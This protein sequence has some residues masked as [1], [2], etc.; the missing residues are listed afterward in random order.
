MKTRFYFFCSLLVI[1]FSCRPIAYGQITGVHRICS[2]D[3]DV[4]RNATTGGTWISSNTGVATIGSSSGLV[5]GVSAGTAIISYIYSGGSDGLLFTVEESPSISMGIMPTVC[6]GDTIANITYT[7]TTGSPQYSLRWSDTAIAAGFGNTPDIISTIAGDYTLRFSYTGDG[8]AATAAGLYTSTSIARDKSGNLYIGE[9]YY[10]ERVRKVSPAGIIT[11]VAGTGIM[12]YSGDGGPA[13][14]CEL[15]WI[16]S[17]T[18]D[19]NGNLYIADGGNYVVRKVNPAG[20]ITTIAGNGTLGFSGDGGPATSAQFTVINGMVTD[21]AGNLYLSDAQSGCIRRIDLRGIVTTVAGVGFIGSSGYSG[22]GGNATAAYFDYPCGLALDIA[23][24]LYIADKNNGVLRKVTPFGIISTVAGDNAVGFAYSGDGGPA[25]NAGLYQPNSVAVDKYGTLYIAQDFINPAIA[26]YIRKVTPNGI[27]STAVGI[28]TGSSGYSGDGGPATAA[29]INTPY[30][31]VVDEVGDIYFSDMTN[32]LIRK[33][34]NKSHLSSSP[35]PIAVPVGCLA[36]TYHGVLSAHSGNCSSEYPISV[37]VSAPP[38]TPGVIIGA[39]SVC[40]GRTTAFT[41]TTT[42][43]AW[44]SSNTAIAYVGTTGIVTGVSAGSAL[45]TY[46]VSNVCGS[47]FVTK[48]IIVNPSIPVSQVITTVAGN[49][50]L[51]FSGD[52]G[53]ATAGMLGTPF[54]VCTDAAGNMYIADGRNHVV[55]KIDLAG[56]ITTFAG[57]GAGGFSGDGGQATNAQLN[58]PFG[59]EVDAIGQVYIA[60]KDN[61]RIRKVDLS[62]VITTIAGTY[63]RGSAGDG[64]PAILAQLFHPSR[65]RIAATGEIYIADYSNHKIRMIDTAGLIATYAGSVQGYGGDGAAATSAQLNFPYDMALSGDGNLYIADC[66]NHRIRV[67]DRAGVITTIAGNGSAGYGG[68]A[69]PA[70]SAMLNFPTCV[71]TDASGIVYIADYGNSRIRTIN[72]AGNITTFAGTGTSGYSGDGGLATNAKLNRPISIMVDNT[73]RLFIADNDNYRIRRVQAGIPNITGTNG[74]C[75]GNSVVMANDVTGGTWSTSDSFVASIDSLGTL[76]GNSVGTATISYTITNTCGSAYTIKTITVNPLPNAGV[77]VGA[78]T[79]AIGATITLANTAPGG[80]WSSSNTAKATVGSGTGVVTG[81]AAGSATISY[82]V[83][84][85]CGSAL[86]TK[87][88]AITVFGSISPIN[89]IT[90]VCTGSTSTLTDSTA[91][92]TWSSSNNTIAT[93]GSVSGV[94]SGV[95]SGTA[96]VT[97]R[98]STAYATAV[99]TVGP[100]STPI[101]GANTVCVGA[102]TPFSNTTTG[103]RWSSSVIA[104][105]AVGSATGIVTGV[106][107]GSATITYTLGSGCR[108]TKAVNVSV[109]PAAIGGLSSVCRAA[110]ITLTNATAGGKWM[111]SNTGIALVGSTT[112]V[113]T[114]VAAGIAVITY[115]TAAGCMATKTLSVNSVSSIQ[116]ANR[117]CLGNS[118][119]LTDST[120]GGIWSSGSTLIARVGTASGIVTGVGAGVTAISYSAGSCRV[121]FT[122]TVS[123]F[124]SIGG[125]SSVCQGQTITLTNTLTGG[126]WSSG[127]ISL[128]TVGSST[129]IV[130]GIAAGPVNI[131]YILP[132]GCVSVKPLTVSAIAAITGPTSICRGQSVTLTNAIS[133]GKWN[134]TSG[135]IAT[136]GSTTGIVNGIA[137]GFTTISYTVNGCR[138]TMPLTV[139]ALSAITGTTNIVEGQVVTLTTV[140]AGRWSSDNIGVASIGSGT[141]QVTGVAA[142]TTQITFTTTTGCAAMVTMTVNRVPAITGDT[143][144]CVGQRT[145]LSNPVAGGTWISGNSTIA[146]I[147]SSTGIVYGVTGGAVYIT[148]RFPTGGYTVYHFLVYRLPLL[149]GPSSVCAG[150]QI[151][152]D[153]GECCGYFTSS[154]S[155]VATVDFRSGTVTGVA[156]G[157]SLISYTLPTG[158]ITST[159]VIVKPLLPITGATNVCVGDTIMLTDALSGG[160]WSSSRALLASVGSSTGI[161]TGISAGVVT[162]SYT[163]PT[164]GCTATMGISVNSCRKSQN[165]NQNELFSDITVYPNPNTGN[166]IIEGKLVTATNETVVVEVV[167]MLGQVV[168]RLNEVAVDGRLKIEIQ[169]DTRIARGI[170]V[171]NMMTASQQKVFHF[172]VSK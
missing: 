77:I 143:T 28:N 166:F 2:G 27:I 47:A 76:S 116:G 64:G 104:K 114:G 170:Y 127:N 80:V 46:L 99:V 36:G 73:G 18:V 111:S 69:G 25:T 9:G 130:S 169:L 44:S 167:D 105:A 67:V 16:S 31:V 84:N 63:R 3:F 41:N 147:G 87:S 48:S 146:T 17:L 53:P 151:T 135:L 12:G 121:T 113:V 79:V 78:G 59:V 39:S 66:Y 125:A 138:A 110:T 92:G 40:I 95:A 118:A 62:G 35:I 60:D 108:V 26:N 160:Y 144:V 98:V 145:S 100:L 51:G 11:T 38:S 134:S 97:Y 65:V 106:A 107:A 1:S 124:T 172:V 72:A 94:V 119:T 141:G 91:G 103:G 131:S 71:K 139:N 52:G 83:T 22:D 162:L 30:G 49:G 19:V 21:N 128:A 50:I 58:N 68:D 129:G 165:T 24:N 159:S 7:G 81:V 133:G 157:T 154:A 163:I 123:N 93:I 6:L 137:S 82:A 132:T 4:L 10:G 74:L 109:T 33:V 34:T 29:Q 112:G 171:L 55:R 164:T 161:V 14:N 20:I 155:G 42:G 54:D 120:T 85:S 23:G 142:G 8:G 5:T 88:I 156:A 168:F 115:S 57:N 148:Y 153:N 149:S 89:G 32:G 37:T 122:V 75:M 96:T 13:T 101:T 43:G 56:T 152:L 15:S 70:S 150:Q 86:A 158:C 102:T 117:I 126:R 45:I 90:T 61:H 136:I 140:G